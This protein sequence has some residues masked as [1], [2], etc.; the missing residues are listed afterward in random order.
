MNAINH[1][2]PATGTGFGRA[3]TEN[4]LGEAPSWYKLTIA[5]FLIINPVLL[6]TTTPFFTGWV[7]IAEFIFT[8]AMALK[9][10]PLQPGGL[11]AIEAV[12]LG[13]TSS[14]AVYHEVTENIEVIL[15]L[16][17]MVAGIYFMKKLLL[18]VFTKLL[19]TVRSKTALSLL[20]CGVSAV[21][22]AFLDALTVTAVLISVA[23][24]FY[25]VYHKVASN[26]QTHPEHDHSSDDH[27]VEYH[28]TDL[29]QF[30]A[31]LRSLIMH[32]AV[33]TA[34][35]GVCTLVGEPQNLLIAEKAGWHFADFFLRMAPVTMPA[36]AA[37]LLTCIL[38][39]KTGSFGYGAKL[40]TAVREVLANFAAEEEQKRTQRDVIELCIQGTVAVILVLALAFHVAEVGMIGLMVIV[41][42]TA[43][44]GVIQEAR[45]GHAFEEALP[46]TAL[47]VV[48]FAIVAVIHEQHLF[49][50]V[51]NFVL[52]LEPEQQPGML[53]LANGILSMI[54]DNVFVATVYINEVKAAFTTGEITR[55]HFEKLAIAINTGTNL[56]SV[57]TPNGQAAFLF[58]LTSALAP[59]IRLSYGRMVIMALPYTVVLS[60]VALACVVYAL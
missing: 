23:V 46:F 38:L 27:V 5:A 41:L 15:L 10:Y 19:I 54:S 22:S 7:L 12:L 49:E 1:S 57:A 31:F 56:P 25:A 52:S 32:G 16:M 37:G 11:L 4:F 47:L 48:F 29:D 8:L 44:N 34:L 9:C 14:D 51:T 24:G 26:K 59:L 36:F 58:L 3:F 53:F 33:G 21:L 43:F 30:R 6:Y 35:G 40:P 13:M 17:F 55:E 42:L 20:F 45:I 60:I 18:H 50:P 39:E 28:R 2:I